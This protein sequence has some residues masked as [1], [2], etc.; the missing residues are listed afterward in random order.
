MVKAKLISL[1]SGIDVYTSKHYIEEAVSEFIKKIES[2]KTKIRKLDNIY[3]YSKSK[4]T[5]D[6]VNE[7]KTTYRVKQTRSSNKADK[8]VLSSY[9]IKSLFVADAYSK[10]I[11]DRQS[12]LEAADIIVNNWD[13]I[14]SKNTSWYSL[15]R[16]DIVCW[17]NAV[18]NFS[19]AADK[20]IMF[21]G[22]NRL[23]FISDYLD[24]TDSEQAR[25]IENLRR[26]R[27]VRSWVDVEGYNTL[28]TLF[29]KRN[30]V[31][32]E[33]QFTNLVTQNN[34][35]DFESYEKIMN[36]LNGSSDDIELSI[37]LMA[38]YNWD[39]HLDLLGVIATKHGD[40]IKMSRA[41]SSSGFKLLK[42]IIQ[43]IN[44][45][46]WGGL[47]GY[48]QERN[49]LTKVGIN[50]IIKYH[51]EALNNV[52]MVTQGGVFKINP[53]A[54]TLKPELNEIRS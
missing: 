44:T 39:N 45:Y 51:V 10:T 12:F 5:R 20:D 34:P 22:N 33:K 49:L 37:T 53:E 52:Y 26:T 13:I 6:I 9:Y 2:A 28:T 50:E 35:I 47:T 23:L 8:F 18:E 21:R 16:E 27:T 36:M 42:S 14:S 40:K 17:R 3:I 29:K 41:Y 32:T 15:G 25:I 4:V 24:P 30:K 19:T 54:I 11:V 38:S 43:S 31:F 48:L 46:S 7:V 1:T